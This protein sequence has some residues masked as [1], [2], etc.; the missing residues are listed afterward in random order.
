MTKLSIKEFKKLL[1][2]KKLF[3]LQ[4]SLSYRFLS[5]TVRSEK[6]TESLILTIRILVFDC[7]P[8]RT[9]MGTVSRLLMRTVNSTNFEP[10]REPYRTTIVAVRLLSAVLKYKRIIVPLLVRCG[11]RSSNING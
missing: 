11:S 8:Y 3:F 4:T 7:E 9:N 1:F 10:H 2:S 5:P 6:R